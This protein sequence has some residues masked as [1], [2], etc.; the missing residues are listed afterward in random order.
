MFHSQYLK[1]AALGIG[2]AAAVIGTLHLN[3]RDVHERPA[4]AVPVQ[5]GFIVQ[6][7]NAR[8]AAHS[9]AAVGGAVNHELAILGAVE[10]WL[11]PAQR[12]RLENT[13]VGLKVTA[14]G[15]VELSG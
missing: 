11:T 9:V 13:Y 8:Q 15:T 5:K 12:A 6:A 10:A 14:N 3:E 4:A 7:I 2:L 1:Q